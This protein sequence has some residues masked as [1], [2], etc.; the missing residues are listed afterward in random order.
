MKKKDNILR[1]GNDIIS[2]AEKKGAH[3][4]RR[5][6]FWSIIGP[7]GNKMKIRPG[8]DELDPKTISNA[9]RWLK[10]LG[11]MIFIGI[12]LFLVD[13]FLYSVGVRILL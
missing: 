5:G 11:L 1:T 4:V 8:N 9:K 6:L 3:I 12:C 7:N 13:A 10:F 2:F